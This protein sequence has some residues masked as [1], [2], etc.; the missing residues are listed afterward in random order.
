MGNEVRSVTVVFKAFTDDFQKKTQSAKQSIKGFSSS[1]VGQMAKVAGGF[2][3]ART[4]FAAFTESFKKLDDIAKLS[5]SLQVDVGFLR[6]LDLAST[7]TGQSFDK[8]RKAL[9]K[10]AR[11]FGEAKLGTGEG[12]RGLEILGLSLEEI[13]NLSTEEAFLKVAGAIGETE[14]A[15]IKAAA[16]AKLMGRSGQ[17]LI[18]LF[19]AGEIGLRDFIKQAEEIGGPITREDLAGIEAANDA[20]DKMGRSWEGIIQQLSIEMA[21]LIE[22]LATSMT[23]LVKLVLGF[24]DAWKKAQAGLE[25]TFL[26]IMNQIG[27]LT[28]EELITA[29]N[30]KLGEDAAEKL[31]RPAPK[32]PVEALPVQSIK[33]VVDAAEGSSSA[34]FDILNP[35]RPGSVQNDILKENQKTAENTEEIAEEIQSGGITMVKIRSAK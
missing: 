28:D 25:D 11:T 13:E 22:D 8:T 5:D 34:A 18:T 17:E 32:S 3:A 10:F 1:T 14:D 20:V 33:S 31:D 24:G 23:K 26:L 27:Q 6:G 16:A 21:P 19:N 35:N 2:I 15:T 12:V 7:Q 4:T 30:V 9:Q 29:L